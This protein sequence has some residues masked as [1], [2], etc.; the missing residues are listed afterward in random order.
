MT[1]IVGTLKQTPSESPSLDEIFC[2]AGR[3]IGRYTWQTAEW[4]GLG[5]FL[6]KSPQGQEGFFLFPINEELSQELQQSKGIKEEGES[7]RQSKL[8][9]MM[10]LKVICTLYPAGKV[11]EN[12]PRPGRRVFWE[13]GTPAKSLCCVFPVEAKRCFLCWSLAGWL[14]QR[15]LKPL[16]CFCSESIKSLLDVWSREIKSDLFSQNRVT[17]SPSNTTIRWCPDIRVPACR[18]MP[19]MKRKLLCTTANKRN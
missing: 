18:Q 11:N 19:G 17:G 5:E 9:K 4:Q 6:A 3:V 13:A 1:F 12:M 7:K 14:P 8:H 16:G 10:G 2:G 15:P